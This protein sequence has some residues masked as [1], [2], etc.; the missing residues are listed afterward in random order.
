MTGNIL[1]F[2]TQIVMLNPNLVVFAITLIS[3]G[4]GLTAIHYKIYYN[5]DKKVS[6]IELKVNLLLNIKG[7]K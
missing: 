2:I 1:N 3:A 7:H 6:L 5:L 4:A